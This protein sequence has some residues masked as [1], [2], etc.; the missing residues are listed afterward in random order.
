MADSTLT[1]YSYVAIVI[2]LLVVA[3]V[4]RPVKI[5]ISRIKIHLNIS[6]VPPLGVLILLISKAIDFQVVAKGFLGSFGVQPWAILILFYSLV[7]PPHMYI[8]KSCVWN[9]HKIRPIFASRWIWREY[10]NFALFGYPKRLE[11]E[12]C[13]HSLCSLS[14]QVSWVASQVTMSSSW[15]VPSF[16]RI[17]QRSQI[18]VPPLFSWAN[19][20]PPTL[21]GW[22]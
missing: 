22:G 16:Y 7:S 21:V 11:I 10:F 12:A 15:Q 9:T 17:S 20:P 18:F 19:L 8:S 3:L 6:T 5:R 2:F 4:I 13:W 14:S 1:T